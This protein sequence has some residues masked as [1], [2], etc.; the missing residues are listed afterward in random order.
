[1]WAENLGLPSSL[2]RYGEKLKGGIIIRTRNSP[3][4]QGNC[5]TMPAATLHAV[6]TTKGGFIG[7]VNYS[8]S[9]DLPLMVSWITEQFKRSIE[10]GLYEDIRWYEE[11]LIQ[12]IQTNLQGTL[13]L[14]L[15]S[16][17][18]LLDALP[19]SAGLDGTE[20]EAELNRISSKA[21]TAWIQA[22]GKEKVRG[23][24]KGKG[25]GKGEWRVCECE[26]GSTV[27]P[28]LISVQ[29]HLQANHRNFL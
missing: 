7:G 29:D 3:V 5:I 20:L 1:M 22:K 2:K 21:M 26:C 10:P 27:N 6:F 14:A 18:H 12:S 4:D 25:R 23:I 13:V 16:L 28:T 11:T 8:V 17:V 24:T 15:A 19:N 9:T